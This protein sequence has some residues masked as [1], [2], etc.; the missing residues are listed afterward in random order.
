MKDYNKIYTDILNITQNDDLTFCN[1]ETPVDNSIPYETYPTF[2]V[3]TPYLEAAVNAGFE[4]FTLANNHTNDQNSHGITETYKNLDNLR[5]NPDYTVYFSGIRENKDVKF[6]YEVIE[7]K[8]WKILFCGMTEC[9]NAYHDMERIDFVSPTKKQR[10]KYLNFLKE[11]RAEY[12]CDFF[13]LAV[14]TAEPEYV[15]TVSDERKAFFREVL[16]AGVDIV[17]GNHPHVTQEWEV[18]KD[19]CGKVRKMIMYSTGNTISGQRGWPDYEN[20]EGKYEYTGDSILMEISLVNDKN[21]VYMDFIEPTIIT[22]HVE[23]NGDYV[24]KKLTQG[25]INRQS[26][27]DR[28]YYTK[29]LELMKQI[30][31]IENE[32]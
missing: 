28:T 29:R 17:W 26:E 5:E 6:S 13:V 9:I 19:D 11:L 32:L 27:K 4:V 2:N 8:G 7:I 15:R 21:G 30:K 22:T 16:A 18:F 25:F 10:T 20:P 31:G 3:Q 12:P 24:I 1:L 14:H 23:S